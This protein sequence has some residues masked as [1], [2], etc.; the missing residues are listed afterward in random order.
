M[1]YSL[2]TKLNDI[3][4]G[5]INDVSTKWQYS[6]D[7]GLIWIDMNNTSTSYTYNNSAGTT[8]MYRAVVS[9]AGCGTK[10]SQAGTVRIYGNDQYVWKGNTNTEWNNTGNWLETGIP[11]TS[12]DLI[13]SET[14]QN[15]LVI[16]QDLQLNNID[17][18]GSNRKILLGNYNLT[19]SSVSGTDASNY[20][21]TNGTGNVRKRI[22]HGNS[23][24]FPVGNTAYNPVMI[25]NNSGSTDEFRVKVRNE[26]LQSGLSG[27]PLNNAHVQRTWDI[28]KG[29]P[30]LNGG[31]GIDFVFNWN[32]GEIVSSMTTPALFH[33][34]TRWDKQ[35][36][37]TTSTANSLSYAGYTGTFSPFAIIDGSSSLPVT[38]IDFS[39]KYQQNI[40]HLQWQTAT[41]QNTKDFII[42][43]SSSDGNWE[44]I[45]AV[46]AAG[47]SD[48]IRTYRFSHGQPS[49]GNNK[50]R[51]IQRDVNGQETMSKTLSVYVESAGNRMVVYP[52][53][54]TAGIV[55]VKV[56][57]ADH[58]YLYNGNGALIQTQRSTEGLN[59]IQV[60]HLGKGIYYLR[61]G[62]ETT[63][64]IVQ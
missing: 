27:N 59:T 20:I 46:L 28:D 51:L 1:D 54:V 8:T 35:T 43:H 21:Q 58:I 4:Q 48:V 36:G 55:Y 32:N 17:F 3:P 56:T 60:G 9:N 11:V 30:N 23:F 53:M 38:W 44:N 12:A 5:S 50:Y 63:R 64:I 33:Y 25:T 42:Q 29:N 26:V 62:T 19:L 49:K 22:E 61:T 34:S 10:N 24:T 16:A 14:A 7:K 15:N 45:G 13:I 31:A 47:N 2:N 57:V 37:A 18:N 6:I 41:E 52:T 40:I 39:A